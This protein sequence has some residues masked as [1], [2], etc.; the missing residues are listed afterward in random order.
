MKRAPR[1]TLRVEA[2]ESRWCPSVTAV[3]SHGNLVVSANAATTNLTITETGAG[4]FSVVENG[5][6]IGSFS[7]VTG[8]INVELTKNNTGVEIN[9]GGFDAPGG[10]AV[11]LG[12]GT[13]DLTIVNGTVTRSL[14]ITGGAGLNSITLGGD[15]KSLDVDKN[16]GV[17]MKG[18]GAGD[19]LHVNSK[20]QIQGN[21]TTVGV[22]NIAL[23]QNSHIDKNVGIYGGTFSNSV[24]LD[25]AIDGKVYFSGSNQADYLTLGSTGSIGS[26]LDAFLM[27]GSDVVNLAGSIGHDLNLHSQGHGGDKNITLTGSVANNAIIKTGFGDDSVTIAGSIG[28][29]LT[30]NTNSGADRVTV[31]STASIN[32]GTIDLGSGDDT[33]GLQYGASISGILN[34]IGG[35]GNNNHPGDTVRTSFSSIPD[36]VNVH[37]FETIMVGLPPALV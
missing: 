9:L 36:N 35:P 14:N 1:A 37:G 21:M 16:L 27:G 29:V 22:D 25:G 7:H 34:L 33:L 17:F 2:L 8:L 10:I 26:D 20:V 13:N 12:G 5:A 19:I 24:A 6:T 31:T 30:A 18:S 3:V 28:G 4:A 11:E 32:Q 15:G 23:D